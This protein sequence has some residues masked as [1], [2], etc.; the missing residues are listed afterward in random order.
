MSTSVLVAYATK[1]GSTEEVAEAIGETLR[2]CGLDVEVRPAREVRAI[3]DYEAV[4]VGA[5]LYMYRWHRDARRFLSRHRHALTER[6]VAIFAL[7]PTH[8]PDH[9]D[10]WRD[11]RAQLD[12][13][14]DRHGW[15]QPVD[16]EL[17]G[18]MFDPAKLPFPINRFAGSEPASD[19]RDWEAIEG[20]VRKVAAQL[21]PGST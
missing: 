4:V 19:A 16:V 18:G 1:Y 20:W 2:E 10:E 21:A 11:S 8:G 6:P 7:G 12:K 13:A 3:A 14:L 17:F 15:L 9:A 5:A